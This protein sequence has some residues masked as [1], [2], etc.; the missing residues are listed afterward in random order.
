MVENKDDYDKKVDECLTGDEDWDAMWDII[1]AVN[2]FGERIFNVLLDQAPESLLEYIGEDAERKMRYIADNLDLELPNQY[3]ISDMA[4]VVDLWSG[5]K[6]TAEEAVD[7]LLND[8]LP[9]YIGGC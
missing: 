2:T 9:N 4:D 1:L 5:N 6:I 7:K 8:V 3:L